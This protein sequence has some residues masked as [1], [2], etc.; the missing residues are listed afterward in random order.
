MPEVEVGVNDITRMGLEVVGRHDILPV[1]TEQ[2]IRYENIEFHP[3]VDRKEFEK[4]GDNHHIIKF[5]PPDACYLELF[6]FRVRPPRA[7][8]LPMQARCTFIMQ[9]TKVEIRADM[10]IPYHHTKAFG[11]VPCED[12]AMRIPIPEAWIYQFR[13]EKAHVSFSQLAAGNLNLSSRMG[14]V[15]SAHRRAGKVKGLE[16]FLGTLETQTQE[17]M[18]T[19]SGQAKYEHQHRAIVWRVPRL[20]KHG[21]G[22]YTNHEFVCKIT[23]ASYDQ[24]PENFEKNFYVEFTQPATCV[25]HT[26]LRN[27]SIQGGSGEPPEKFV[28]YLARHEYKLEIDFTEKEVSSYKAA[29]K[30]APEPEPE[31]EPEGDSY[32][33][34]E[35]RTEDSDSDS[36]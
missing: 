4:P 15:K 1:P 12:V 30:K 26:V 14:A 25:S 18:E 20:P 33:P 31:P 32:F 34:S 6:R 8:E 17:L 23:L 24:M 7:R 28:K 21:Q 16:R 27:V 2:W 29:V 36:D 22:S 35:K 9:G 5:Q 3:V 11:Q 13:N 10:M 19:S